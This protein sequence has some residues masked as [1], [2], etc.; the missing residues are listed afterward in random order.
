[1]S[2]HGSYLP[3]DELQGL[4]VLRNCFPGDEGNHE[5]QNAIHEF[6]MDCEHLFIWARTG[7]KSAVYI[8]VTAL[9]E[10]VEVVTGGKD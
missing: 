5:K 9:S 8:N 10:F 3:L 7:L 6:A 2:S 1:M 4:S